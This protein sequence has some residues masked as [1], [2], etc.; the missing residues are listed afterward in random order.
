MHGTLEADT[1]RMSRQKTY[2]IAEAGV[3][4]NGSLDMARELIDVAVEAGADA[5]KFQTFRADTLALPTAP[6]AAYQE[7]T[8]GSGESQRE[9]LRRLELGPKEHEALMAHCQACGIQ[10]LSTPFDVE[11][12]ELLVQQLGMPRVKIPSG[13]ITNGPFLFAAASTGLPLILSTGMSTLGEVEEALGVIAYGYIRPPAPP[14]SAAF[15]AAQASDEG[16]EALR[17][18]V[19]LLHCT[20][21]YPTPPQDVHLRAMDTLRS[22]FGLAVGYS[23][24][25]KGFAVPIAAVARGATLVEKHFTLDRTLK[26]P[27]HRASMEPAELAEM[28]RAIREVEAALGRGVKAPTVG[29]LETRAVARKSLVAAAAIQAGELLSPE[30]LV[31]RRPGTGISPMRYWERLGCPAARAFQPDEPLT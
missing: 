31:A 25:T 9:M 1:F 28:V 14:G 2:I 24:H 13:E 18:R 8:T 26:G 11:S 17:E 30:N 19:T 23:D 21:E 10:F 29:E 12:L 4:H 27:D 22:A 16:Q 5:V 6:K 3:N 15:S 20:S 7:A